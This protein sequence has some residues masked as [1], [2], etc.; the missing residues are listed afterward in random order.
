MLV[1]LVIMG[2]AM[3]LPNAPLKTPNAAGKLVITEFISNGLIFAMFLAFFIP[4]FVYGKTTGVIKNSSD[5]ISTMTKS[6]QSMGAYLVLAFFASQFVAYFSHTNLGIILSV[7][8]AEFL[9]AIGLEGVPLVVLFVI[10]SAFI[11][12]FM[13]SASAKWAIMAPI[14]VPMMFRMGI[15]PALT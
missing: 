2:F 8:G 7:K 4:G 13:G 9:Q 15:S 11:N 3:F 6:M 1:Y 12:L 10:L 14:F 5:L